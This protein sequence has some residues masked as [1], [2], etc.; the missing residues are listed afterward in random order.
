MCIRDAL[1]TL[2]CSVYLTASFVPWYCLLPNTTCY[3]NFH[4]TKFTVNE[5]RY[6][7]HSDAVIDVALANWD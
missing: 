5:L 6:L 3:V 2:K 7:P 4:S 1:S